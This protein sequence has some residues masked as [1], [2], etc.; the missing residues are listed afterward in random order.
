[1]ATGK[2]A[3]AKNKLQDAMHTAA[4]DDIQKELQRCEQAAEEAAKANE[5]PPHRDALETKLK[6]THSRHHSRGH[7]TANYYRGAWR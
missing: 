3:S 1:M 4:L 5:D 2:Y 6:K 7:Y